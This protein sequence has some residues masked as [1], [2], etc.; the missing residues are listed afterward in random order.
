M[1]CSNQRK[2]LQCPARSPAMG[3]RARAQPD[4][5]RAGQ[6]ARCCR[7]G[8]VLRLDLNLKLPPIGTKPLPAQNS[9]E[10]NFN[11]PLDLLQPI[12]L[13]TWSDEGFCVLVWAP[14][15]SFW[16]SLCLLAGACCC[17]L[18]FAGAFGWGKWRLAG[19]P[20]QRAWPAWRAKCHST[21]WGRAERQAASVELAAN[22][23]RSEREQ[24]W[25]QLA[26]PP[27]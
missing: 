25:R 24:Q 16:V 4:A 3:V 10:S 11:A 15:I 17:G 12:E 5:R 22:N 18:L 14:C 6:S 9:P 26:R 20:E 19:L 7:L 1:Q 27:K 21:W 8:F 2:S 23:R 13:V